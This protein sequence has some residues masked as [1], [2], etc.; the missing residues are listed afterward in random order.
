ML[1]VEI[2][3]VQSRTVGT[4]RDAPVASPVAASAHGSPRPDQVGDPTA[5]WAFP[6]RP[7][8]AA[9]LL[10]RLRVTGRPRPT[11]DPALAADLRAFL[12]EGLGTDAGTPPCSAEARTGATGLVV[13]KDRITRALACEV[14][15]AVPDLG[16]RAPSLALARGAL[17]DVL[18]RQL[19][20]VGW[21]GDV[22]A[23]GLDALSVDDY[24]IPLVT[25]IGQ[26][27]RAERGELRAEVERQ[28]EGLR[29]RW[30]TFDPSWLP[31]TQETLRVPLGA[32]AL[33]ARVDLAL[34]RPGERAASVAIVEVKS[35]ARRLEHRA[36]LHFYALV[37]TLRSTAPPFVVATYYTGTGE[38]DIDPVDAGLLA[39]AARRC[40]A[41][42][43]A[44]AGPFPRADL[45]H[46]S[47]GWCA[48]CAAQPV[49]GHRGARAHG[50]P[51][52]AAREQ[53]A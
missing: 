33:S 19:V 35:G 25:W 46:G 21:V 22:L 16:D 37:E 27:S 30:P 31:R 15:R 49:R 39:I 7:L 3:P 53:A 17:V 38:V 12:E 32:H 47:P 45:L 41:G 24:Q 9:A 6:W 36:D 13:T 50:R 34:G 18:F 4:R 29:E 11:G 14:H 52:A 8:A 44:M 10:D 28:I 23:D 43:R 51:A 42:I 20:T 5:L 2:E 48:S 40:L 26:L 1:G